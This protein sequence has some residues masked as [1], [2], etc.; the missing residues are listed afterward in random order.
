[1]SFRQ[2][3]DKPNPWANLS[4]TTGIRATKSKKV[5]CATC[6]FSKYDEEPDENGLL[7]NGTL[8]CVHDECIGEIK[9]DYKTVC[10]S[11][12]KE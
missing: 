10:R 5:N 11:W 6:F 8:V 7:Q 2:Q 3:K 1:M 9:V 4:L 12:I